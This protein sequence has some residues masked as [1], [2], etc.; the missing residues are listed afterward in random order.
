MRGQRSERPL[1]QAAPLV[2]LALGAAC[3]LAPAAARAAGHRVGVE[4]TTSSSPNPVFTLATSDGYVVLPDGNT[5]YMWGFSEGGKPFQHPGPVL[6]VTAGDTVTIVLKNTLAED[7]SIIFPGQEGVLADGAP[8]Q[9]QFDGGGALTSLTNVA[10]ANGGSVSYSFVASS[11][12]SYIYESGTDPKK[13]VRMG[14]FGALVVKP[15]AV[16]SFP[17]AVPPTP[18]AS[19]AYDRTDSNYTPSEDFMVLL[20][21]IDPF[22]HQAVEE[23]QPFDF[24][25]YHPRYWLIN[26]RGFPDSV[27]DNFAPWLPNQPYGALALVHPFHGVAHPSPGRIQ[28][29]NVG[30]EEFPYHPHGNNGLVIGRD[31]SPVEGPARE[32]LSFE[33]F[34]INIGPGQTWDV[35][36]RWQDAESYDQSA[37]PVPVVTRDITNL[38]HGQYSSGSPYL[39]QQGPLPTGV[40]TI[41]ECGEFYIISHNHALYQLVSWGAV[42]TGPVTYLRVDPPTP[43]SCP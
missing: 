25:A 10:A 42:M 37:H 39:G 12:G 43:N 17:A 8:A 26:G 16:P 15:A 32:D 38:Q 7:V 2:G 33:K 1:S 3:L 27:A 34:A 20:S 11:A 13:Q 40:S 9:P 23:G 24:N 5:M 29:L 19:Y 21:E 31:G 41:N 4:C 6:C 30:T 36:F 14:L 18:G 35:T 22:L 28:Y